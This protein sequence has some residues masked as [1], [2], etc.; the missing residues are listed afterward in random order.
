MQLDKKIRIYNNIDEEKIESFSHSA[1]ISSLLAKVFLSRGIE[2]ETLVKRFLSPSLSDLYSPFLLKDMD[3]AVE[4]ILE[5]LDNGEKILIYGDYDADGVTSTSVLYNFLSSMTKDVDFYI[6]HRVKDGYGIVK[7]AVDKLLFHEYSLFIS[8]DCGTTAVSEIEYINEK[9]VD[10]IVTDHHKCKDCLPN[11]YAIINPQRLDCKYPFKGLAG[12]GVVY[13][14]VHA[15][16]ETLGLMDAQNNYLD[17][18]ALGTI[19][20]IMPL[21]GENRIIVK[22]GLKMMEDTSNIGLKTLID[23]SGLKDSKLN[24]WSAGFILG[25]RINAGGRIGDASKSVKLFTTDNSTEALEIVAELNSEN[26]FRQETEAKILEEA[27]K[28]I[29]EQIDVNKERVIVTYG[30]SWHQGVIGIVASRITERY[31]RPCIVMSIEDGFAKGSG[32]SIDGFNLF[33][34]L[35]HCKEYLDDFGGHELAAGLTIKEENIEKF[36]ELINL[37]ADKMLNEQDFYP[38]VYIDVSLDKDDLNIESVKELELMEPFGMGNPAPVF[39][40][41]NL[42]IDDIRTVGDKKHLKIRF[43][44]K[45]LLTDAIGFNMGDL[46]GKINNNLAF[47]V[48]GS[49][50]INRWNN[51]EKVQ[52]KMKDLRLHDDLMLDYAY[53]KSL[54]G[55]LKFEEPTKGNFEIIDSALITDKVLN[56]REMG[57][58]VAL[59][60]NSID[61][62]RELSKKIKKS[63]VNLKKQ[64]K[65]CYTDFNIFDIDG[66][67]VYINPNPITTE[68]RD[69]DNVVFYGTWLGEAY[70]TRLMEKTE[71]VDVIV[72]NASADFSKLSVIIPERSD[73]EACYRQLKK[74]STKTILIDDIF[75]FAYSVSKTYK[76]RMN[77]YKAK[78]CIEIFEELGL[79]MSSATGTNS[80]SVSLT[81]SGKVKLDNSNIYKKMRELRE[82]LEG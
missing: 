80:L 67:S 17:L 55:Y 52:L 49:L 57:K 1:G 54:D 36:R 21:V 41:G 35:E 2:D 3:K 29:E 50:E 75:V 16:S 18:V 81:N 77:F 61:Y 69:V 64:L 8:V 78:K 51:T 28:F 7:D 63:Y 40:Y 46:F 5:A 58:K 71:G 43:R 47:D 15:L 25:P 56:L 44:D 33:S 59:V 65:I 4:R 14:L 72:A 19:A 32:R 10:I 26:T 22:H 23:N 27:I 53:Y 13:K 38:K 39:E 37:Y 20:D 12:V 6:P 82:Y 30:E 62:I 42:K 60:S 45:D 70:L 9:G 68:F 11:A 76:V 48:I 79:V 73:L 66:I 74:Y 24:T 34:A 31:M